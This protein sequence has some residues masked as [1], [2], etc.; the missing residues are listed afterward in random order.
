MLKKHFLQIALKIHRFDFKH[1]W[2]MMMA[3]NRHLESYYFHLYIIKVGNI[4]LK[5][6]YKFSQSS[7]VRTCNYLYPHCI[8]T[9]KML[10]FIQGNFML[11][12]YR[13]KCFLFLGVLTAIL[14]RFLDK[15]GGTSSLKMYLEICP[16]LLSLYWFLDHYIAI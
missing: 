7:K 3:P 5:I 1:Q 13:M 15:F 8:S 9:W 6:G 12:C 14:F 2:I 4:L 16:I 10:W 11:S